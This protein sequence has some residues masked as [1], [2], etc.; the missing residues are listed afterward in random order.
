MMK[1]A[2]S[3]DVFRV[4]HLTARPRLRF[5]ALEKPELKERLADFL[6]EA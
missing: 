4:P 6:V 2:Q 1:L 5:P 3:F